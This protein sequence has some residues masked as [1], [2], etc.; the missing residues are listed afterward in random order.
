MKISLIEKVKFEAECRSHKVIT[1]QPI[2]DGGSDAGMSP[3]ELLVASLG[4]CV[5][6]YASVFCQRH[7]IPTDGLKVELDWEFAED[8]HRIG[9]IEARIKLPAKLNEKE[10]AGILRMVRGCTVHNTLE[11]KPESR[12]LLT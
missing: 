11:S 4:T 3:V 10:K 8:P 2:E 12:I 9:S 1:D 5:G 7:K 6:Y